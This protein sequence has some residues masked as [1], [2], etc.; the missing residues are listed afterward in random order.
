MEEIKR[1]KREL[2]Y[3]GR[4][5]NIYRDYM[6]L[7]NGHTAVWDYVE[8]KGAAA[9]VA[10]ADDGKILMVRQYRNAL[11]RYTL[12][13]PAG[14]VNEVG[15]PK[16]VCAARELEEE[17]IDKTRAQ[18]DAD[19][20]RL[21]SFVGIDHLKEVDLNLRPWILKPGDVILLCSDGISGVLSP[22]ELLEAMSLPPDEGCA[23][24]ETMVLEKQIPE[25]DNYT[26]VMIAC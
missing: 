2:A 16:E 15:E 6:S 3:Q 20:R 18:S 11:E 26:G 24:L 14:A 12:E 17:T 8:H 5:L 13:L 19:A 21:T 23:L 22:P 10:V 1:I 4:I 9:V 25:Q 7:P